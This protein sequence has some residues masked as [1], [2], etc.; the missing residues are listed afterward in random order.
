MTRKAFKAHCTRADGWW[1]VSVPDADGLWTQAKRLD[2]V[3]AM[4]RDAIGAV[5]DL[6]DNQIDVQVEV[7]FDDPVL[8]Q[9]VANVHHL[10][11]EADRL[12]HEASAAMSTAVHML[13]DK[14][15]LPMRDVAKLL[16][17]SHQRVGQ[18]ARR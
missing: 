12:Q 17:V 13:R 4:A 3:E 10:R 6:D 11:A 16:G 8:E 15:D 5:M 9:A 2:Q 1:A 7:E 14:G 18:L